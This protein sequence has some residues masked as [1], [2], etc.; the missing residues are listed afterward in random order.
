MTAGRRAVPSRGGLKGAVLLSSIATFIK[1]PYPGR[2]LAWGVLAVAMTQGVFGCGPRITPPPEPPPETQ[3]LPILWQESGIHSHL[4]RPTRLLIRDRATLARVPLTEVPVDFEKQMVLVR[5]LGPTPDDR[6]SVRIAR[7]WRQG[8][9]I[10]V[11][12]QTVYAGASA[13]D[14]IKP[15][16]PWTVA[17]IPRSDDNVEGYHVRVRGDLFSR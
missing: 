13:S 3:E 7:V 16:S 4:A 17:V 10:R 5:G 11:Q 2:R 8:S 15:A 6:R 12:E 9:V 14:S 1:V